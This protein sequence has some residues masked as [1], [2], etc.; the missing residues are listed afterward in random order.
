MITILSPVPDAAYAREWSPDVFTSARS[1]DAIAAGKSILRRP[2]IP[3]L[4]VTTRG[5]AS[6]FPSFSRRLPLPSLST[7]EVVSLYGVQTHTMRMSLVPSRSRQEILSRMRSSP[8]TKAETEMEEKGE[9]GG[10]TWR[11][12]RFRTRIVPTG[13][14]SS[15]TSTSMTILGVCCSSYGYRLNRGRPVE[16]P[17]AG[18]DRVTMKSSSSPSLSSRTTTTLRDVEPKGRERESARARARSR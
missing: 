11:E 13:R 17:Y 12:R 3:S 4:A 9:G 7:P 10:N 14:F 1:G 2:E 18:V 15:S 16:D 8:G 5:S 6:F